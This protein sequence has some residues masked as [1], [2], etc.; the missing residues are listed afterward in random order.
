[1][2]NSIIQPSFSS[3]E[4]SPALYG[5][6]DLAKYKTGVARMRNFFVDYR[7]GASTRPGTMF[8]GQAKDS[9]RPV[10]LIPFQFSTLNAFVLEFGHLYMRVILNGAYVTEGPKSVLGITNASPG[11]FNVFAHGYSTGDSVY[12]AGGLGLTQFNARTLLVTVLDGGH[13]SLSDL[14]GVPLDTTGD[15]SYLGGATVARIY[16]LVT[17]YIAE[18]LN[19][20]KYTQSASIMTLT[21]PKYPQAELTQLGSV[22]WTITPI[23]FTAGIA[24]PSTPTITITVDSTFTGPAAVSESN[25]AYKVTAW[26]DNEESLPSPPGVLSSAPNISRFAGTVKVRWDPI[27]GALYYFVY[28]AMIQTNTPSPPGASLG[29][30]GIAYG[31]EFNDGNIVPDFTVQPPQHKNP[32][33]LGTIT[34]YVINSGGSG[35]TASSFATV[36]D[37]TGS[38]ASLTPIVQGG[39]VVGFII[40]NGGHDYTSPTISVSIGTG[41]VGSLIV[42]PTSGTFPSCA[43]YFQ[44]RLMYA[45]SLNQPQTIWGTK[46]GAF[47]N[48]DITNPVGPGD[49]LNITLASREVNAIRNMVAMPGGLVVFTVGGVWQITGALGASGVAAAVTPLNVIAV[50]QAYYG[51]SEI[52][53]IPINYN[54]LYVQQLGAVVR[55]LQ[56][57]FYVSIYTSQDITVYSSHLLE[58]HQIK[59]WAY[60]SDPF[61]VIW[62]VREDGMMLSLTY[63]K[64]QELVGWARHDT[65]GRFKSVCS[66]P[67]GNNSAVYVVVSRLVRGKFVQ[68]IER[69]ARRE[70]PNGVEDA[71]CVDCG[72]QLSLTSINATLSVSAASGITVITADD[73]V[74]S[75]G[76]IGSVLRCGGGIGTVTRF[77]SETQLE[78][79]L[80]QD[81]TAEFMDQNGGF[82]YPFES[83]DWTLTAPITSISGLWHLEG[84]IVSIFVDGS[85][86][87][88]Q[89]VIGGKVTLLQAGTRITIGLGYTAQLQT[90]R[91]D[92][93][94]PTVQGKRKKISA[95]TIRQEN[96]RGLSLGVDFDDLVPQKERSSEPYGVPV[97]LIT[98]DVRTIIPNA[99]TD[100][101][102]VAVEQNFPLPATVLAVIPEVIMGDTA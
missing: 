91:L 14:S 100:T 21:H 92:T 93:G 72:L 47:H 96:S 82:P 25:Y 1:M 6:V 86:Q 46:P 24:R 23:T 80:T 2:V 50:P 67:E 13:F 38:G 20:L 18:D 90:L 51:S 39:S 102:Q 94:D 78:V 10:E 15:P 79:N 43:T 66:I 8:V 16:T 52:I 5:R 34:D 97:K 95:V 73:T 3:G 48:M 77:I 22:N 71:W 64:E 30:A 70:F 74:F 32:F 60:A 81:I 76:M 65:F 83:G 61:K 56:Y 49:A 27:P 101:G 4:L 63:M 84:L 31:L 57:D 68:Y 28:K 11:V 69:M 41:F 62:I 44:Q 45:N 88:S 33:A 53:P 9:T 35:Y 7:G 17:P 54:I 85:V 98:G 87:P 40:L 59:R 37:P 12:I 75:M 19:L 58:N 99:Y 89:K 55:E 26:N 29:F 42:G 36:A